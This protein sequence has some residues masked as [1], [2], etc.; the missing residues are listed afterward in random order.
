MLVEWF[1]VKN[2]IYACLEIGCSE[3]RM[4]VCNIR[5]ERLYVLSKQEILAEGIEN[6][7]V[8]NVNQ[9]VEILK[10]LKEKVEK[11]LKQEI[12]SVLLAIP[13]VDVNIENITSTLSVEA[14]RPISAANVKQLFRQ[15]INQPT[16]RDQVV[17]NIIPRSFIVDE[18]NV[19]QNPLGIIGNQISLSAQ[20]ITASSSLVYNLINVVE[21]AGLRI[22][23]I[24]LG[25]V[26]EML[27]V[28]TP[29]QLH[30]G[31]C[32]V[33]IGKSTTTVTVSQGGKVLSS[34]SLSI[35]G[36]N[37]TEDISQAFQIEKSEAEL[38]KVNFARINYD[39]TFPEIIYTAEVNGEFVCITRQMLSDVITSRYENILKLVKQYLTENGY[40]HE[41]IQYIF[42]GGAVEVEG[43]DVLG[44]FVFAQDIH[45]F[46]P[47]MLGVRNAKYAKL[48]GMATFSHEI[49]LLT[50]QKSNI[51]DFDT[52]SDLDRI[53]LMQQSQQETEKVV[54]VKTKTQD[55]SYMDHKL[56]NSG[57][58]VRL[59]DMIFDEKAE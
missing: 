33:N 41:D 34:V 29:E 8:I 31:V 17:V 58:L 59:F 18:N 1:E 3:A 45:I 53:N 57:V 48:I 39:D 5:Q 50:A 16:Y 10:T 14:N 42:T 32:H 36:S 24:V 28:A 38:L 15:V 25:S 47:S 54:S 22:S 56:E 9:I 21:L 55:K 11:D 13:S 4:I 12:Q 35:G 26:A 46:R 23:D 52:Y 20:K 19:I 43:L 37:V 6:G 7:N 30:K 44:K 27:Y 51:I 40:K 49:A 2:N